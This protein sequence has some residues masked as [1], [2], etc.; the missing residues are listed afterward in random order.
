MTGAV[1]R[2]FGLCLA[3][4][5]T[6]AGSAKAGGATDTAVFAMGCFWC[7]E[8][9]FEKVEGVLSVVS[10]YVGGAVDNPSYEQVSDGG[11]G[12]FEAVEVTYD[13]A[14]ISYARLLE[15]F[16]RGVDPLDAAGQFCDKGDQYRAAIF[17]ADEAQKTAATDALARVQ[18]MFSGGKIA[19]L[20]VPQ[21]KF[22]PAEEYHQD[23]Y[24]K[25]P[26]RYRFYRSRCGR[27]ARLAEVWG[28]KK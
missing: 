3:F 1:M 19:T 26:V 22:W 5:L 21:A 14:K 28:D 8:S 18:G 9:D 16:W 4:F 20:I 23:Y 15:V 17:V 24:R 13:P 12:H 7:A 10:G 2:I 11:T 6:L 27:D 25:N